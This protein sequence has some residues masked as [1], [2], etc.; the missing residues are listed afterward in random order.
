MND[1]SVGYHENIERMERRCLV[2]QWTRQRPA[3]QGPRLLRCALH[4]L[5][6]VRALCLLQSGE[7]TAL[8][9]SCPLSVCLCTGVES[10]ICSC[11]KLWKATALAGLRR[12]NSDYTGKKVH[13]KSISGESIYIFPTRSLKP[14]PRQT[15]SLLGIRPSKRK[16]GEED[17]SAGQR[18]EHSLRAGPPTVSRQVWWKIVKLKQA[19]LWWF[20]S[21]KTTLLGWRSRKQS[22]KTRGDGCKNENGFVAESSSRLLPAATGRSL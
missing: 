4:W 11:I 7:R 12:K 6:V 5:A 9:A 14:L 3:I 1:G 22:S 13:N 15:V 10:Q 20:T 17:G 19:K 18:K 8:L 21:L 2:G 16:R